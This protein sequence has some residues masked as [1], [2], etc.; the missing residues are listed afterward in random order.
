MDDCGKRWV[1]RRL[2]AVISTSLLKI[3]VLVQFSAGL[4]YS[5]AAISTSTQL[6]GIEETDGRI[7]PGLGFGA[8]QG[9]YGA[10]LFVWGQH[11]GPI[12]DYN[13]IA[14]V[15]YR[16]ALFQT[17]VISVR[18]GGSLIY[19]YIGLD[20]DGTSSSEADVSLGVL[21]GLDVIAYQYQGWAVGGFWDSYLVYLDLPLL[22]SLVIDRK[23]TFGLTLRYHWDS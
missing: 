2:P 10:Q 22:L 8:E 4:S 20:M 9:S 7:K 16:A 12:K 23:L 18:L 17:S 15:Y 5:A 6:G 13:G 19:E 11:V 1:Q 14:S 21:G 3:V